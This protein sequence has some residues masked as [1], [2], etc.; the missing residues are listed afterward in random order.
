MDSPEVCNILFPRRRLGLFDGPFCT[1][2]T[3]LTSATGTG[4]VKGLKMI[5]QQKCTP[6][7]PPF[8]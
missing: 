5:E 4:D 1:M 2:K 3:F 7:Q 6:L 8:I